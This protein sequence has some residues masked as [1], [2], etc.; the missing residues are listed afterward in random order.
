MNSS[1]PVQI[2]PICGIPLINEGDDLVDLILNAIKAN[3][4]L[5]EIRDG[6]IVCIGQKIVSKAYG[7]FYKSFGN[8]LPSKASRSIAKI[9]GKAPEKVQMILNH[10]IRV[11]RLGKDLLITENENALVGANSGIDFSNTIHPTY[12]HPDCD[13][14]ARV[15]RESFNKK[16]GKKVGVIIT[17]SISRPFRLG[18]VGFAAGASGILVLE[19]K[20]DIKDLFGHSLQHTYIAVA[21]QLATMADTVMGQCDEKIPAVIIRNAYFVRKDE[22]SKAKDLR[23]PIEMDTFIDF[24]WNYLFKFNISLDDNIDQNYQMT[25]K[26]IEQI[27]ENLIETLD[28]SSNIKY[29]RLESIDK[30]QFVLIVDEIIEFVDVAYMFG[31]ISSGLMLYLKGMGI[32]CKCVLKEKTLE[33]IIQKPE[34]SNYLIEIKKSK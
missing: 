11:I 34:N 7:C 27:L 4:A 19:D 28:L 29:Y 1:L 33:I 14:I 8:I 3:E 26:G 24:P 2:F 18:S 20:R 22:N 12:L 5:Y 31:Q 6:D 9:T 16:T 17:D 30:N 23:R 15:L 25:Q 10:A 32:C 13:A 21:D